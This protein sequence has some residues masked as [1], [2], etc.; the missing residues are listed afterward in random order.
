VFDLLPE[1]RPSSCI[2]SH[3]QQ[4]ASSSTPAA[5]PMADQQADAQLQEAAFK[6]LYLEE[7]YDR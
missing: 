4:L 5:S 2:S 6:K 7:Y 3:Q 1:P